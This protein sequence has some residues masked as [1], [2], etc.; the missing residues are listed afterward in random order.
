[1]KLFEDDT[2]S[3]TDLFIG[4]LVTT[5]GCLLNGIWKATW[6]R[7]SRGLDDRDDLCNILAVLLAG[8]DNGVHHLVLTA[9]KEGRVSRHKKAACGSKLGRSYAFLARPFLLWGCPGMQAGEVGD[10]PE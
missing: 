8:L 1:M 4:S 5:F 2:L 6:F 7:S 3:L 10:P 9:D